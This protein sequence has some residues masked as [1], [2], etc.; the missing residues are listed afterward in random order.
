[1]KYIP[2]LKQLGFS[3]QEHEIYVTLLEQGPSTISSISKGTGIYRPTIYK[4]LPKL[5]KQG[6]ITVTKKGKR[7]KYV[8]EHPRMLEGLVKEM[9]NKLEYD[10]DELQQIYLVHD[11]R[12][13]VKYLEG[14]KGLSFVLDDIAISSNKHDVICR[15]SSR[16]DT[17]DVDKYVSQKYRDMR[18]KKQLERLVITSDTLAKKKTIPRLDRTIKVVPT[19]FDLFDD[20]VS[21]YIYGDK[22]AFV[23]YNSDSAFIVESKYIASFQ[24][25]IFKL[26]F[27]KL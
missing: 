1:M 25:K 22:V 3:Q 7:N 4:T 24:K 11:K 5:L 17:T 9:K 16:K 20:D 13:L 14:R 12:P 10:F 18:E 15:Y 19:K 26:L 6:L 27:S 21:L 23:D 2:L 8:A